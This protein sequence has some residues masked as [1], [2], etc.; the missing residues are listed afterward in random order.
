MS[1][2]DGGTADVSVLVPAADEAEKREICRAITAAYEVFEAVSTVQIMRE[3]KPDH[4]GLIA[5]RLRAQANRFD[6]LDV[7]RC[8]RCGKPV[9]CEGLA[10]CAQCA[11][12]EETG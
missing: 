4:R 11:E 6:E 8:M 3:L 9:R 5:A 2:A 12:M 1:L 7:F 10:L